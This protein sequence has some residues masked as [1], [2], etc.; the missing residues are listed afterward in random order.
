MFRIAKQMRKDKRYMV[1][2][3]FIK[4][5]TGG[6]QVERA[7]VCERLKEYFEALINGENE[8]ELEMEEGC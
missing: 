8:S 5:D 4:S 6:I 7:E 1:G 3:N 2:T